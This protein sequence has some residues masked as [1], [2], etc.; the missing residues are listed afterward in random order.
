MEIDAESIKGEQVEVALRESAERERAITQVIQ[1]MRQTLDLETIFR[2]TTQELRQVLACDRVVVYQFNPDWSGK[3]V[4]E[5]VGRGW[6][7]LIEEHKKNPHLISDNLQDER[8]I[9][10]TMDSQDNHDPDTY[11]Q[12]TQGGRY[13]RGE[14]YLCVPDIYQPGFEECYVNLLERFQAKA[15]LTVPIFCGSQIWGLLACYQNSAP[16]KWKT[17]DINIVVQIG[18]Q[19]GVALQQAE[20]LAQTQKQSQA[21]QQAVIAADAANRA[22]SEFLASMSHELRTPLNA[23]LGFT[24]LMSNDESLSIEN[25]QNLAI[26]NRAGEHLLNLINDILEMSKIEAGR[27][28]LNVGSFD[29]IHLLDNLYEMLHLRASAKNLQLVFD[30]A[31]DI[32]QY[33]QTDASKLRQVLLNLL[34]NAIKFTTSGSVTLRVEMGQGKL[35]ISPTPHLFFEVTDTGAGIAQEEID[36]LFEPFGQTETGRK[37]QQGT[38]LGLAISRKYIQMMGGN[39]SVSSIPE[40]GST[41]TFDIQISLADNGEVQTTKAQRQIIGL[42]PNQKE[43][44]ILVVDDSSDSRLLLSKLLTSIGFVVREAANGME[45]ISL[46]DWQPH[47]ILMD[48]RMP[49]M[50]GYEATRLLREREQGSR[51]ATVIIAL[52]ASAF[53]EETMAMMKAGC[54]DFINKP[55]RHELL[56]EKLSQ[57]LGVEYVY[58]EQSDRTEEKQETTGDILP[59]LSQMSPEWIVQLNLAAAQ[60]S[61]DLI[62]N[63]LNLIPQ[64]FAMLANILSDLA[65]NFEFETIM[66]LTRLSSK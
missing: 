25:Q 40:Q 48:M 47:L 62:L 1:R 65:H 64:E 10:Q 49:V 35:L 56:L 43:Y 9:V 24:Q 57:H 55:F 59:L 3:F 34:G 16:R 42:V 28:T 39:I 17:G 29:L 31:P 44:R 20:L 53:E 37:S 7:S 27:T 19:L 18:N 33:I 22:K 63:L 61:D 52:S 26:I 58:K 51:G 60:G 14:T 30:Y 23:I 66:E 38:G 32:P 50:D 5:S 2:A 41:F 4:A 11:L 6:I 8:C 21:L 54:D 15:Y 13:S 12:E 45:A 46:W 36:L